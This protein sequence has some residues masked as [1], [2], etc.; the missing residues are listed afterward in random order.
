MGNHERKRKHGS[1]LDGM[2]VMAGLLLKLPLINALQSAGQRDEDITP[3]VSIC[4]R[5]LHMLCCHAILLVSDN[6]CHHAFV[7][8]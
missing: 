5:V 6:Y 8:R 7:F 1:S 4:V 3:N 2:A